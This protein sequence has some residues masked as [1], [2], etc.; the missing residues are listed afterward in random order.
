MGAGH[1]ALGGDMVR[2]RY[3][4][5]RLGEVRRCYRSHAA[6]TGATPPPV[7]WRGTMLRGQNAEGVRKKRERDCP[8]MGTF[9][10]P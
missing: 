4:M 1:S 8:T 6:V 5:G 7:G 2:N 3:G 10:E 9:K